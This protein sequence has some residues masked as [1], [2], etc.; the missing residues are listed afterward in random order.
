MT[1]KQQIRDIYDVCGYVTD[2]QAIKVYG[3]ESACWK[4]V[5]VLDDYKRL[6]RD[7]KFFLN[8]KIIGKHKGHRQYIVVV[9]EE[10][11]QKLYKCCKEFW[12]SI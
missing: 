12:Q 4:K 3:D 2:D 6:L 7:Q 10:E 11:E 8:K 5:Q 1:Y 9:D